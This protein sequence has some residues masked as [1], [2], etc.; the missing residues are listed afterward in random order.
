M[1]AYTDFLAA[2]VV[3][4]PVMGAPVPADA[5]NQLLLPHQVAL[6]RWAVEGGRRAI[7]A[8]FGL[9]KSM[10]QLETLR[11]TLAR[12]GGEALIVCPLGVRGEFQRDAAKL[13]YDV[14]FIRRPDQIVPGA[15]H[16]TNYETVRDGKLDPNAFTAVSLDEASVLRSFGSKTYQTFL[17]NFRNRFRFVAT[18]TPS[19]NRYKELIH[20]A[21][22]LGVMDAGQALTRFF[23]RDSTKANHLTLY[24][25]KERE[26]YLWLN[27][28]AAFV[29][30]PSDLGYSDDGYNLPPLDVQWHEV[31]VDHTVT[32]M[33]RDGQARLFRGGAAMSLQEE[34]RERRDTM[35][36]RIRRLLQLVDAHQAQHPGDQIILWCDLNAEQIAIERGLADRGISFASIFGALDPDESERR[37]EAW[38]NGERV[39]LIGKPV[40]LGQGMNLQQSNTCFYAGV[41]HKFNDWIQSL[42]RIQ[43][44]GQTRPCTA[45]V[46]YAE[47]ETDICTSLRDKWSRHKELSTNMTDIIKTHGLDQA[48]VAGELT[49]SM[50]VTRLTSA[51]EGWQYSNNDCVD[52]TAS[53]PSDSVDLIVTSIPFANHYEYTPSYNDFGHTDDNCH[54]WAQ[55]DYLTPQ[56]LRILRPGRIYACHVKDRILFGN[57][58]GAGVPTVSPFHA[59]AIF[60]A[61]RHGFDY[62][63]MITVVTD[64][65][66]ENNQTY[67]LGW[68]E[69]CKDGTKMGVGSP[70]YVLLFRAPQTD[71]TRSYADTP[72]TK[73][74][75][76][77]S[78]SRWQI[79][80]HAFWRSSGNRHLTPAELAALPVEERSRLFTQ[81]TLTEVYDYEDHVETGE[82]LDSRRALPSTFMAF[83]P[84]SW[85]PE[86]WHDVNRMGTLNTEQSRKAQAYHVCPLQFDI[87]DRL[88]R[89][90]SNPGDLVFDP[91]G[92]LG[93]VPVRAL[94]LGRRGAGVELNT[95][96]Y[97]DALGYLRA[98][99]REVDMPTL[100]DLGE[101]P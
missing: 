29:Q 21:G 64:V 56:L 75:D 96:Y 33:D 7:F 65:V 8:A 3:S 42:H 48:S 85:S 35:P 92:G 11:L 55:M 82:A 13:G 73:D 32:E 60:H 51:G 87:V 19:P 15:I 46:V 69:Q 57:V 34:A 28:W 84:G 9:G 2:K 41:S 44:F 99:E 47:S 22:F 72:V 49:R 68:T 27:T 23:Q 26:F 54:F 25:H 81:Q 10:I 67:R 100:F 39:A 70:E 86:V 77:Y 45:H 30:Y 94:R 98:M 16:V 50:G 62:L 37:L 83:A 20:Y 14:H 59:E 43:R 40:M 52:E 91:F 89:R 6:V 74:K 80:A 24:P 93:T 88:I 38:R 36:E 17:A 53:M 95:G 31:P 97:R 101:A 1:T 4:S 12:E 71:R 90:Y 78:R 58:T 5:V 76:D 18:A 79:D 66:R 63:G 61:C